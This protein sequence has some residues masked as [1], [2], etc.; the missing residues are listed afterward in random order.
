MSG[1]GKFGEFGGTFVSEILE[2]SRAELEE[3]FFRLKKNKKFKKE[4]A[5]LLE[6]YGGRPTPLT[7]AENLS[8]KF[9]CKIYLKR[10]DLLHSGAHK[11]N[12]CLGQALIAKYLGKK[13][14]IAETGA[15][16]HGVATAV[17]GAKLGLDVDVYMGKTDAERQKPNV[18]RMELCGAKVKIV[19]S[20]SMTLKDAINEALRDWTATSKNTHYLLGSVLGPHPYPLMVAHFQSVIGKEAKKQ[21]IKEEGRFPKAVIA[22]VGGGSNAI[23]IFRQFLPEKN[24]ELIGVEAAGLGISTGKHASRFSDKKLGR[25]GAMH[26]CFTYILQDKFGQIIN[27]HSVAAGLDYC[28]VGPEHSMLRDLGR[29]KY[30]YATDKEALKAFQILSKEEGIIPALE[31]AHAIAYAL[32]YAKKCSPKDII[33]INLSGRGDKDL[34]MVMKE[35]RCKK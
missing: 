33:L 10:E 29:I 31:S 25:K 4:L 21:I 22:C 20:G 19:E 23:G 5:E 14:L 17:V 2:A 13:K 18:F 16:Q 26:G 8:K 3:G 34:E 24:V 11:L 1:K 12:N 28:A 6:K 7:Y 35:I 32:K 9:G 15:G 30:A 27:T